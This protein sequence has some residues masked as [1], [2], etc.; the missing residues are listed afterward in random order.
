[1]L[2]NYIYNKLLILKGRRNILKLNYLYLNL[3]GE[4][5]IGKIGLDFSKKP[6]RIKIVQETISRKR[7]KSFCSEA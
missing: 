1:M 4:K 2:R 3:F 6:T 7:Y 5:N